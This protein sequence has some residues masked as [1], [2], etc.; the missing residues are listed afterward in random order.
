[1][2]SVIGVGDNTVDRYLHMGRMFPGGN[3]VNVPV[4]AHRLGSPAA[5]L[6]WLAKEPNGMLIYSSLIEEGVDVSRCRLVEGQNAYCEITLKDGDRV[7]GE[8]S[9][10]V[11]AQ[12][13]LNELDF[14]FISKFE[15]VH[16]SV[17][18][19]I[20]PY[21]KQLRSVSK[22]LSYDFSRE[23]NRDTLAETLPYI[24]IALISNPV[25][26]IEEN[27]E[28]I[29][30]A[31]SFGPDIVIVT[32]GEQGA[33]LYDGRQFFTQA[34]FPVEEVVDTLGAGDAF[35]AR[36]MVDY[37]SGVSAPEALQNAAKSAAET[38]MYFGA[39]GHGSPFHTKH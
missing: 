28:L 4:M 6:G 3:S 29:F 33:L 32:S 17:Y 18:S 23:W 37:L 39:F 25:K 20:S 5:Y 16:T 9:E 34:V 1:M 38:C 8:Y 14:E 12:I 15:L 35:A 13:A 11:C 22:V 26:D 21:L 27:R 10:G 7:F 2:I 36:F 24:D 30:Y 19:F 31:S